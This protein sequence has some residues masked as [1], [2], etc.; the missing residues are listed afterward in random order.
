M[1][2]DRA[3]RARRLRA[4]PHPW[5]GLR[6]AG[7]RAQRPLG[8]RARAPSAAVGTRSRGR[9]AAVGRSRRRT[10]RR[11]RRLEPG[12]LGPCLVGADRGGHSETS[13][14][15]TAALPR[16]PRQASCETGTVTPE[17]GDVTV[18]HDDLYAGARPTLSAEQ[19]MAP[20][21]LLDARAPERFLGDVEPI[22]PVAGHI[23]GACNAPS[24]GFLAGDGT[25]LGEKDLAQLFGDV[26]G[27]GAL[28]RL[29]RHRV[30]R[31][32]RAGHARHR[33]SA[34]SRIVVRMVFGP[35]A[36]RRNGLVRTR[37]A[38]AAADQPAQQEDRERDGRDEHRN[39]HTGRQ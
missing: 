18:R 30:G 1:A 29:R 28:L 34:V 26:D 13:A 10:G 12:R 33:R 16:G 20:S 7:G 5:R 24:T 25:F 31:R 19:A 35:N 27:V 17:P 9:R 23:P 3:G 32:G 39:R 37:G 4:G 15:S 2:A 14:S 8:R 11:L 21:T 6:V 22:D 36:S 38:E